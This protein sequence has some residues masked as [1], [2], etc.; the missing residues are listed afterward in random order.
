[1][2]F[3]D[4]T[5]PDIVRD[6]LTVLTGGTVAETHDIGV[7]VPD[8]IHLDNRPVRRISHLAGQVM[9]GDEPRPYRFTERDFEL[10]GTDEDPATPVAI[11]F[12]ERGARPAPGTALTVNYYPERLKPTPLTDVNVG[13]VVRTLLETVSREMAVMYQQ[14]QKVYDSA[15][16]ETAE[17]SSLDKVA[18]LVDTRRLRQGHSVGKVRFSRRSGSQ[19]S[20][21]IPQ[22]TAVGDGGTGRYLTSAEAT[23]LPN[24]STIEVWVQGRTARVEPVEAGTLTVLERAIAGIDRATNDEATFRAT[25]AETDDQ[26]RTRAR[27]AIHAAGKGTQDAI[28]Y[29]LESLPFVSA[30]TLSE[31]PDPSVP[32]PGMLRIDVAL[33]EDNDANRRQ[34]DSRIGEYRPA[35]IFIDRHWATGVPIGLTV[36]LTLA[37][38]AQPTSVVADVQDGITQRLGDYVRGIGPGETLRKARLLALVMQDERVADAAIV[39]TAA[40]SAVSTDQYT[41]EAGKT[42]TLDSVTPVAYGPVVFEEEGPATGVF[43]RVTAD[44]TVEELTVTPEGLEATLTGLLE[45]LLGGLSPG[46]TLSF[47]QLATAI[48]D[49]AAFALV[50]ASSVFA[51]DAEGGTFSE[52]RDGDPAYTVPANATLE[53]RDINLTEGGGA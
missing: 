7:T 8:L 28:R 10:V 42:A 16:V 3:A 6:L 48:R 53:L 45:A 23:L 52:L 11:R 21:F 49:D 15:F 26:L 46:D 17:G 43:V 38:P 34:V 19:G 13:S 18:A 1:M 5:Y 25:E 41:L 39:V 9:I 51:F 32:M 2:N 47:D 27:R 37:G 4:R 20:V 24:Q 29:G 12:R 31:Y 36:N 14:L 33:S 22:G 50:R 44:L 40:G 30:A 35:G